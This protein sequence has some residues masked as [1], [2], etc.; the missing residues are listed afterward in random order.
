[1]PQSPLVAAGSIPDAANADPAP[2]H[3]LPLFAVWCGLTGGSFAACVARLLPYWCD[4][5][6]DAVGIAWL[7]LIVG[8]LTGGLLGRGIMRRH[9][10][11]PVWSAAIPILLFGLLALAPLLMPPLIRHGLAVWAGALPS[12]AS[13]FRWQVRLLSGVL[14]PV[15]LLA[16]C[17]WGLMRR[18]RERSRATGLALAGGLVAG[19]FVM[20]RAVIPAWGLE[21]AWRLATL[22]GGLA[23]SVMLIHVLPRRPRVFVAAA[24]LPLLLAATFGLARLPRGPLMAQHA[25]GGWLDTQG[26]LTRFPGRVALHRDGRRHA[27]SLRQFPGEG[28]LLCRDGE[29]RLAMPGDWPTVDLAVHL[30][31]LLHPDPRRLALVGVEGGAGLAAAAHHPLHLIEWVGAEAVTRPVI[32]QMLAQER[33]GAEAFDD[34]RV[35]ALPHPWLRQLRRSPGRYDVI[36]ALAGPLWRAAD[37]RL[38]S[39][40][41][42]AIGRQALATNG[43]YCVALDTLALD[44]ATLQQVV[45]RFYSVFPNM[46]VW[47]PQFNRYLLVGTAGETVFDAAQLLARLERRPVMRALARVG[48]RGLPDLLACLVMT[49]ANI[50]RFLAEAPAAP[51]LCQGT[52]LARR[53]ARN[54]LRPAENR[55]TIAAIEA[56]RTWN[57]QTLRPG[58]MEPALFEALRERTVRQ[59]AARAAIME[60]RAHLGGK[61]RETVIK[62]AR[63]SARLNPG[64]AFLNRLLRAIEQEATYALARKDYAGALR[65]FSD[66]V[67]VVP[68]RAS[69]LYGAALAERGLGRDAAAY[70]KLSRAVAASPEE[71]ACRIALAETAFALG[72]EEEARQHYQTVLQGHP[73]DP[74]AL[75][76]LAICLGRGKPPVRNIDAAIE[77]AERA[78]RLTRYRDLR[79][80]AA[81]ADLYVENGR[82]VEGVS[83]KRRIRLA[84]RAE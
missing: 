31:L 30:P 48:V 78:A 63:V 52:R 14:M 70:L 61:P 80:N 57:L 82:V 33:D 26:A 64:D 74:E 49:P 4:G 44:P 34:N 43:I 83:L 53:A 11:T 68:E 17:G 59:M 76:G 23:A 41:S 18:H 12:Y 25:I 7:L 22:A 38:L 55:K 84:A 9:T 45:G 24:L 65:L 1:M 3:H 13:F 66:V 10:R 75:I 37:A 15:G 40:D 71:P 56:A 54:R 77:T 73:D 60:L 62:Q 36:V 8:G 79:I 27:L 58:G 2:V 20:H 29:R 19:L 46:Q 51:R 67:E 50:V 81:L 5:S 47:S 42:L 28:Y 32:R 6:P 72:R 35:V 69:A 16:G 21:V 39:S